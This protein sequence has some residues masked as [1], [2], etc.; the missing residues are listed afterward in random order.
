MPDGPGR[1]LGARFAPVEPQPCGIAR[2]AL[3]NR[4]PVGFTGF[5]YLASLRGAA[6]GFSSSMEGEAVTS[7]GFVATDLSIRRAS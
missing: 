3:Q 6:F 7:E 5:L 4:H 2:V 1:W